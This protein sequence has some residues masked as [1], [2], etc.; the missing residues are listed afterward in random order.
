MPTIVVLPRPAPEPRELVLR[1][2]ELFGAEAIPVVLPEETHAGQ[3][4]RP[5][6]P[7]EII[8]LVLLAMPEILAN[9]EV[10]CQ[11]V[12]ATI[13]KRIKCALAAVM[14]RLALQRFEALKSS[15][16]HRRSGWKCRR[17]SCWRLIA[18][19]CGV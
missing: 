9:I 2:D 13:Q 6:E 11:P 18:C 10:G 8:D 16:S 19:V 3:P 4:P 15:S 17:R 7:I 12:D 1:A 14:D 5:L